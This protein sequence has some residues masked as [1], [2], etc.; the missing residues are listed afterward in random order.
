MEIKII[1]RDEISEEKYKEIEE[2]G[3]GEIFPYGRSDKKNPVMFS[4]TL[5]GSKKEITKKIFQ[6]AELIGKK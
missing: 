2:S 1:F 6:L 5:K 4:L 3:L